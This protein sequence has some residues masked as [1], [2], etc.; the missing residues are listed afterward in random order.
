MP[1]GDPL[2]A[3]GAL[4]N[5]RSVPTDNS[6]SLK[7]QAAFAIYSIVVTRAHKVLL[8]NRVCFR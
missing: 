2:A 4:A 6:D 3:A 7:V 8:F 1:L 5:L